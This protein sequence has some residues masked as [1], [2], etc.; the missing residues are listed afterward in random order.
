MF[1]LL[2]HIVVE[3]GIGGGGFEWTFGNIV[4]TC[5]IVAAVIGVALIAARVFG[6]TI[7]QWVWQ[8][9]GIVVVAVIAIVAVRFLLSL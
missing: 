8:I 5:I 7:P 3:R 6:V 2:D 1:G 9:L 4:I